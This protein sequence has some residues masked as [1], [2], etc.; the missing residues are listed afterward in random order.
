MYHRSDLEDSLAAL[1]NAVS[2]YTLRAAQYNR[3]AMIF[4]YYETDNTAEK[5]RARFWTNRRSENYATLKH[6]Y[7][8]LL[9]AKVKLED[10]IT[11]YQRDVLLATSTA[12]S[13]GNPSVEQPSLIPPEDDGLASHCADCDPTGE[14]GRQNDVQP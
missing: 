13:T 2:A 12:L 11:A 1:N 10:T 7:I 5:K 9:D 8:E 14:W 6:C 4:Y 3:A